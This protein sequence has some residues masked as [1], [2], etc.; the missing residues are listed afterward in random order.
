MISYIDSSVILSIIFQE[1]TLENS[2]E[3][4][5][6]SEIRVSSILLE[7]E[8]KISIKRTYFHNKKKLGQL[9]KERKLFELEKLFEEINLKNVDSATIENLNKEDALS[10]CRTLDALHLSTAIEIQKE[11]GEDLFIFSYDKELNKVAKQLG[12][13]TI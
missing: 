9:W 6:K 10:G 2:I 1:A 5:K 3:I 4:W 12:F 13:I 7:A 8:C 11:L